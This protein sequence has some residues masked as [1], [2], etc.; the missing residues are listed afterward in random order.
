MPGGKRARGEL[1][2]QVIQRV[3]ETDL[4]IFAAG[5]LLEETRDE[6]EV[7]ESESLMMRTKYLRTV[8]YAVLDPLFPLSEHQVTWN[9]EESDT[10]PEEDFMKEEADVAERLN[11]Q[12]SAAS[13]MP[14]SSLKTEWRDQPRELYA[15]EQGDKVLLYSW[16][17]PEDIDYL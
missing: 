9:V 7:K 1:P 16:I 14:F 17:Y 5:V 12:D 3:L 11:S 10:V 4:S 6:V 15:V 8:H 2:Q 13:C